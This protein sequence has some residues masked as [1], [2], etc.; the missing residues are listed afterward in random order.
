ML[1]IFGDGD[2]FEEGGCFI[3]GFLVFGDWYVVGYYIGFGLNVDLVV[4][5]EGGV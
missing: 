5:E 3:D 1:E 4:F 2:G